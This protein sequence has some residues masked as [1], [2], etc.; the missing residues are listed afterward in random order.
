[1][2][3]QCRTSKRCFI[4]LS[5]YQRGIPGAQEKRCYNIPLHISTVGNLLKWSTG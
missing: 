5:K 3:F 4:N 2:C 1:I